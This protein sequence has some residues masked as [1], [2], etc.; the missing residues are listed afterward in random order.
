M[1]ILREKVI[2]IGANVVSPARYIIFQMAKVVVSR[3]LCAIME[4][5]RYGRRFQ[6]TIV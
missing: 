1:T 5:P 2:K 4:F 6:A 3:E